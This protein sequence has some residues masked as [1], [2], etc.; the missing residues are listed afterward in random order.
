MDLG[1][2][3]REYPVDILTNGNS[4]TNSKIIQPWILENSVARLAIYFS[5]G[6]S[7]RVL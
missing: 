5:I 3:L 1:V 7:L 6:P 2:I 4:K